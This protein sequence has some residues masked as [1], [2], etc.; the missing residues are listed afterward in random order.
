MY[1]SKTDCPVTDAE[2]A[3][4]RKYP[5]AAVVGS[6]LWLVSCTRP[7][8]AFAVSELSKVVSNPGPAHWDAALHVLAYLKGTREL[9]IRYGG[10][11][12]VPNVFETYADAGWAGD[13]DTRRSQ[14]GY[15]VMLN[16]GPVIWRSNQQ[17]VV[18]LSSCEA[19]YIAQCAAGTVVAYLRMFMEELGYAQRAP[20]VCY[21]D[22]DGARAMAD[23]PTSWQR[24]KHIDIRYHWVR[25]QVELGHFLPIV[26]RTE[27]M[28]AD[29]FTKSLHADKLRPL[30]DAALGHAAQP[31]HRTQH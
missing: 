13:S 7:D 19:E 4:M 15:L 6:L 17:S 12:F 30:R 22:N 1:I 26:C 29:I 28:L 23:H 27:H 21:Q 9:G 14:S 2:K 8:L 11:D 18:A 24:T 5:Y 31:V 20:S 25:T 16:G 3:E 10:N